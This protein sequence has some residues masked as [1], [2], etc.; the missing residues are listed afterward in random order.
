MKFD[1][2]HF[3]VPTPALAAAGAQPALEPGANVKLA[4][5]GLEDRQQNDGEG[6]SVCHLSPVRG[7]L[8][9]RTYNME[10]LPAVKRGVSAALIGPH[11]T[12]RHEEGLDVVP[13]T[14]NRSRLSRFFASPAIAFFAQR[15]SAKIY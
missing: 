2:S 7:R 11:G 10:I 8:D 6:L 5:N 14:G 13:L 4:G 3:P 12:E 15:Q 9:A 1:L